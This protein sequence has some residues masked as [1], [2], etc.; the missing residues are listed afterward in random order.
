[1]AVLDRL[2]SKRG[3]SV[4]LFGIKHF[5]VLLLGLALAACGSKSGTATN[6]SLIHI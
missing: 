6:L 4:K 1:M 3:K 5:A 2:G